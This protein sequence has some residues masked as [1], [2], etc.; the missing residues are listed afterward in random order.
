MLQRLSWLPEERCVSPVF[1][2][3]VAYYFMQFRRVPFDA[4]FK[5]N[6]PKFDRVEDIAD[7]T[8]LNEASV[9]HNLR[10]RYGSGAIY[11]GFCILTIWLW[12]N[13]LQTYSGLFLVAINPYQNLPLYSDSIIQ[14][15]RN[16]RRDENPPHIFA[17]AERAWVNMGEERE[18]QSILIT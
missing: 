4:L 8:F 16:K 11:V 18:N 9:V 3:N 13:S 2:P 12:T 15:Y 14:Q 17:V 6:P 1:L 7:L 10:L 5:M